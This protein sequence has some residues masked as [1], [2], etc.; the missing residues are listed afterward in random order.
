VA[1][2][3][4]LAGCP[5][6]APLDRL[7]G[8]ETGPDVTGTYIS[9]DS[10]AGERD[11]DP[12][13]VGATGPKGDGPLSDAP[14]DTGTESCGDGGILCDGA[15]VDPTSDPA[16]CNGCGNTCASG[17]CGASITASMASS[18]KLW[19]FNGSAFYNTFAPSAELTREAVAD[20]AGTF[21]YANAVTVDSMTVSFEF[22]IGLDGGSR[23]DGMGFMIQQSSATAVGEPGGGLGMTGL[24]GFGVE[25]DIFDNGV[26]GDTSDDHVGVDNLDVCNATDGTPTSLYELD[27]TS[28]LDLGDAQWHSADITVSAG[29]VSL[30][31]DGANAFTGVPLTGF[32][33]GAYY[34][35][36]AGGTG[37]LLAE[38][39]GPGGYRQEV[40]N[41]VV[42]FPTPQCL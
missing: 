26:C 9:G 24:A 25:L 37:G 27:V 11:A 19:N 41:V 29:S 1:L 8:G 30:A 32:E 5:L 21:I 2:A 22:R 3:P 10:Q 39:G 12:G 23:C 14:A 38:D 18:P 17:I 31:I 35:G 40:R 4:F 13:D 42:N 7:T 6:I 20:Q 33:S 15:C 34:I 36:F 16:N 28:T